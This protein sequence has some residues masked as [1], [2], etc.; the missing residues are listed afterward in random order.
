METI[1]VSKISA[2][3]ERISNKQFD[4]P[5]HIDCDSEQEKQ[6][7]LGVLDSLP[8]V[9]NIASDDLQIYFTSTDGHISE[10]IFAKTIIDV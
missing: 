8:N 4:L 5:C 7:F 1:R 10:S 2:I 9:V 3:F 6:R